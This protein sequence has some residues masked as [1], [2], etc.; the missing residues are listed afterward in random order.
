MID[1]TKKIEVVKKKRLSKSER[2]HVR[3]TKQAARKE[4][5]IVKAKKPVKVIEKSLPQGE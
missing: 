3:R 5:I 1:K 4:T 2:I